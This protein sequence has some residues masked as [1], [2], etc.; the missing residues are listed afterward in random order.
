MRK[1]YIIERQGRAFVLYAGLLDLSHQFGLKSICTTLL[2]IPSEAN[3]RT[4]I[5]QAVVTL[6]KD[7][8]ERVFTGIGDA[9]PSNV[10]PAMQTCLIRMSETRAKARALR[11]AVNVGV[12]AFEE[13]GDEEALDNAPEAGSPRF[14]PDQRPARQD[15]RN[16]PSR[17]ATQTTPPPGVAPTQ[18]APKPA[19][20]ANGP[21]TEA[22]R[23]AIRSLCRRQKRDVD[24]VAQETLGIENLM[25]LTQAQASDLIRALNQGRTGLAPA[26]TTAASVPTPNAQHPTPPRAAAA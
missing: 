3:Q 12:A 8:V 1:E 16:A 4:A 10:A 15:R 20:D 7:G 26:E 22:Q 11:D 5:C 14:R 9:N 25:A 24:S 21:M 13:L 6:E 2:Q 19:G 18:A 23:E 17:S